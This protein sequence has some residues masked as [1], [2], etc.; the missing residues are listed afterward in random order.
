MNTGLSGKTALITGGSQGIG[1]AIALSLARE[2]VRVGICARTESALD[3]AVREIGAATK[4]EAVAVPADCTDPEQIKRMVAQIAGKLGRIDIL[5]NCVGRAKAGPFLDLADEDWL[6]TI[7][8]KLMAAVRVTRQVLPRMIEA[9]SGR[10][11]MV[12]GVFGIQPNAFSIPMG[13]V[14]AG[15]FNFTKALAA[16]VARHNVLV[17][18]VAPGRVDTPLF[19][20]LVRRQSEQ[21]RIGEDEAMAQI[22]TE[23]PI[24][25]A[26]TSEEIANVV[27]FLASDLAS[28]KAGE[29]V[30]VDGSWVKCV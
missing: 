5:V 24:G 1:K 14:N 10:V 11:I 21:F 20:Q 6:Q 2:G 26:G 19:R 18:A 23:V 30:T 13:V 22:L 25:R 15:L 28:Y 27:T 29:I 12:G 17:N 16:D 3:A 7:N 4:A 8:L 9:K